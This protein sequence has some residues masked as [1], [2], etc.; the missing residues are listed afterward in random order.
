MI[1]RER[2]GHHDEVRIV[3]RTQDAVGWYPTFPLSIAEPIVDLLPS[4]EVSDAMVQDSNGHLGLLLLV[5]LHR[6][7][8]A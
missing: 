8:E 3:G 7:M 5:G 6:W 4:V 2:M 1:R